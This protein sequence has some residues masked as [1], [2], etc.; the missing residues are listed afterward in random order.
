[1]VPEFVGAHIHTKATVPADGYPVDGRL[2]IPVT[3]TLHDARGSTTYFRVGVEDDVIY[4]RDLVI[5]PCHD[6]STSFTVSIDLSRVST[7]RHEFRLTANNPDED[8]DRSGDQRMFQST[9]YQICVRSCKPTYRHAGPFV[10]AR[11]WYTDVDYQNVRIES[12]PALVRAGA[13]VDVR[14]GPGAGGAKTRFAGVY[15]DPN[16]HAGSAGLVVREWSGE[17]SGSVR[18]PSVAPGPHKLVLLSSDGQNAGVLVVQFTQDS[19]GTPIPTPA[20]TPTPSP[21]PTPVP[22]PTPNPTPSPT[23]SPTPTPAPQTVTT[24]VADT[25]KSIAWTGGWSTAGHPSYQ[26]DSVHW[27]K[28]SGAKATLVFNGTQVSWLGPTGPT[29]GKARVYIDG[30]L[31]ATVDLYSARFRANGVL[32]SINVP[33][34]RHTISVVGLATPKRPVVAIDAFRVVDRR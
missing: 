29:R 26:G 23:P 27:T 10:E 12:D 4:Q 7:G 19:G 28:A 2:E 6:C 13:L 20:P 16:F 14:F 32:F 31:K 11:G 17:Y 8:P 22:T 24:I 9:G 25:S 21:T 15:I 1:V 34:G 5:G 30:K 3:V 18:I 33:D